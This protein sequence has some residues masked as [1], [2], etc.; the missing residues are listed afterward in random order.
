MAGKIESQKGSK[1]QDQ[2]AA[3]RKRDSDSDT[4]YMWGKAGQ[5]AHKKRMKPKGYAW[6]GQM[7]AQGQIAR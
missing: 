6:K 3:P 2:Q 1:N 4:G 5:R 7:D